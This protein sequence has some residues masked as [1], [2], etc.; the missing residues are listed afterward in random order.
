M[1][2]RND[3]KNEQKEKKERVIRI[4][5]GKVIDKKEEAIDQ[6]L[7]EKLKKES[8]GAREIK[9]DEDAQ[10]IEQAQKVQ[11]IEET[12]EIEE[13]EAIEEIAQVKE[14]EEAGNEKITSEEKNDEGVELEESIEKK[15]DRI[16]TIDGSITTYKI[17]TTTVVTLLFIILL[18][19]I[20]K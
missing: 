13:I 6:Q 9:G 20:F 12:E 2:N 4:P 14:L 11:E 18:Y 19:F 8:G 7:K 3:M 5:R 1:R 10:E 17:A 16:A 15:F